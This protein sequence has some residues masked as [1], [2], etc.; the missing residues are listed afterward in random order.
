M[1]RTVTIV[2]AAALA[3]AVLGRGAVAQ[4]DRPLD[5]KVIRWDKGVDKID[6]SKYPPDMKDKYRVFSDLCAR[7]HPL[8]RAINCDFALEEDWERYIK[9]MMRRGGR[10]IRP[11]DA[12][13]IFEFLV[14]DSKT[15]K[16]ALY[17]T[18]LAAAK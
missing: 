6:V 18:K 9:K 2:A 17:E 8:A 16:K 7:C 11:D 13:Q 4:D 12:E 3:I 15:R 5:P 10:L 14:Y 1:M